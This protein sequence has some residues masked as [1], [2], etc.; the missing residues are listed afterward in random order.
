MSTKKKGGCLKTVGIIIIAFILI[1]IISSIFSDDDTEKTPTKTNDQET[2]DINADE[3][4]GNED[5]ANEDDKKSEDETA[6]LEPY[7]VT[8]TAGHYLSGVDFP[9]G[10]YDIVAIK[11]SGNV[12][13]S[14]MFGGGLNET[15][16]NKEDEMYIKEFNNAKLE[17]EVVLS[18]S[19]NLSI[20]INSDVADI[21]NLKT[22]TNK[23]TKEVE[24][25]SG[26]YVA[27]TDFPTGTYDIILVSGS[28]NVSSSNMYEGGLNEVMGTGDDMY[29]Q[30]FKNATFEDGTTVDLSG[31]TVKLVPSK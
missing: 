28:G 24:L 11:G 10:T 8:L 7:E 29:I 4:E 22:R 30:E 21:P 31:V 14:N 23:L 18:I 26:N 5:K 6:K 25:S 16:S 19:G 15:M 20:K 9:S 27:G 1:G 17:N 12:S 3:S 2:K 13:S